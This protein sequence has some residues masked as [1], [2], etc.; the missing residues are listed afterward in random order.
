MTSNSQ[1][2]TYYQNNG[3]TLLQRS[4]DY[5][6]KNKDK[7]KEY[8][9]NRFHEMSLEKKIKLNEYHKKWYNKLDDDRKNKMRKNSLDRYYLIKGY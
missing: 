9:R 5:Y 6:E 4:K 3:D 2:I 1:K 8:Q 7:R